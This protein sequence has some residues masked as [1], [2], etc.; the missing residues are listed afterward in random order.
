MVGRK[1]TQAYK[2][3]YRDSKKSSLLAFG[4]Q[5]AAVIIIKG[6]SIYAL[7][8]MHAIYSLYYPNF[9][10]FGMSEWKCFKSVAFITIALYLRP[11]K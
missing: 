8:V 3:A 10:I 9:S 6:A 5:S 2:L 7:S 4:G 1:N 11:K